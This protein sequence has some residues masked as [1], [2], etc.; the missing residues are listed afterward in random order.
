MIGSHRPVRRQGRKPGASSPTRRRLGRGGGRS[1]IAKCS[2][3]PAVLPDLATGTTARRHYRPMLPPATDDTSASQM[4]S[5]TGGTTGPGSGTTGPRHYRPLLPPPT[6]GPSAS[7]RTTS[8]TTGQEA[9]LPHDRYYRS[10]WTGTTG[11]GRAQTC[12]FGPAPCNPLYISLFVPKIPLFMW[13]V[14]I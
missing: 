10:G 3:S 2:R 6:E 14:Y 12:Y 11:S 4:L 7:P 1:Q 9:V 13:L 8:G 5:V